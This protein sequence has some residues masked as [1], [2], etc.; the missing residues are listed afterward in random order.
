MWREKNLMDA[1]AAKQI[2]KAKIETEKVLQDARS[3]AKVLRNTIAKSSNNELRSK[4][5]RKD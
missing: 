2:V 5:T 4:W 3:H 1:G